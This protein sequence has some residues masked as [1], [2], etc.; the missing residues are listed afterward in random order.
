M[1]KPRKIVTASPTSNVPAASKPAS[2]IGVPPAVKPAKAAK[3]LPAAPAVNAAAP[4]KPLASLSRD[5]AG[6]NGST[7][8]ASFTARDEQYL[9]F[10]GAVARANGNTATVAQLYAAGVSRPGKH[11]SLHYIPG[12]TNSTKATDRDAYDRLAVAGYLTVTGDADNAEKRVLSPTAKAL[13]SS[14][15]TGK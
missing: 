13:A 6:I 15:Y 12:T 3:P 5:A 4:A 7:D 14:L 1:R 2:A 9:R 11:P 10:F 8:F